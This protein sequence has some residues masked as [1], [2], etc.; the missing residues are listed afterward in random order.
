M[1]TDK[2]CKNAAC[3]P[4]KERARFT[5]S[6]GLYLEVEDLCEWERG[7]DGSGQLSFANEAARKSS[8]QI[9]LVD[10]KSFELPVFD[11]PKHP[12]LGEYVPRRRW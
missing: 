9:E 3:P 7:A 4:D 11:E 8:L 12:R 2:R 10:L 1:L 6:S 5:E